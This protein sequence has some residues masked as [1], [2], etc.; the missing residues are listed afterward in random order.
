[1]AEAHVNALTYP[2][3]GGNR[4]LTSPGPIIGNDFCVVL[5]KDFPALKG[6]P[7]GHTEA[8]YRKAVTDKMFVLDGGKATRELGIKYITMEDTLKD[9][10]QSLKERFM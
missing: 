6:V 4:F 3:A 9:M 5:N 10:A 1:M 7:K 2:N 8:G